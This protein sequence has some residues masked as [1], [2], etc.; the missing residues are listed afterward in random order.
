MNHVSVHPDVIDSYL[1]GTL[2]KRLG[3][4]AGKELAKGGLPA[5]EAAVL[6]LLQNRLSRASEALALLNGLEARS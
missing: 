5:E 2:A 1:D 3:K 6:G 4:K